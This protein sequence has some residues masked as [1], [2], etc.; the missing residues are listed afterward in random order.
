MYAR[1]MYIQY[2]L[3]DQQKYTFTYLHVICR[4][5]FSSFNRDITHTHKDLESS[6]TLHVEV[7]KT[8]LTLIFI[9]KSKND[10]AQKDLTSTWDCKNKLATFFFMIIILN[11]L[12]L[13]FLLEMCFLLL[14]MQTWGHLMS[15]WLD[16]VNKQQH[17]THICVVSDQI[18]VL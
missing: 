6:I 11:E 17:K 1:R 10:D 12:H 15:I 14:H 13:L 9:F 16:C 3:C 4:L 8:A 2:S 18:S 5:W 7:M